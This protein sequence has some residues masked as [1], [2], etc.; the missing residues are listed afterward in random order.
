M[1]KF[2]FLGLCLLPELAITDDSQTAGHRIIGIDRV[3]N[4]VFASVRDESPTPEPD[5]IDRLLAILPAAYVDRACVQRDLDFT[6]DLAPVKR[7]RLFRQGRYQVHAQRIFQ[8]SKVEIQR[9]IQGDA[10]VLRMIRLQDYA[11][12]TQNRAHHVFNFI[13]FK[14]FQV[15][16]TVAGHDH[17]GHI[18]HQ[19][20][21]I[22]SEPVLMLPGLFPLV[23]CPGQCRDRQFT[24]RFNPKQFKPEMIRTFAFRP[25][26]TSPGE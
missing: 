20:Y 3:E 7:F 23:G 11:L 15:G 4:S 1:A 9:L 18:G 12:F 21:R 17:P 14:F 25:E 10:P 19:R 24:F 13:P 5:G 6:H 16:K 2:Y 8:G 22:Q 26:V